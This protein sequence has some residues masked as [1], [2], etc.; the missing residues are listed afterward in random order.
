ML[1]LYTFSY[2]LRMSLLHFF[3]FFVRF[4]FFR[5]FSFFSLISFL[6]VIYELQLRCIWKPMRTDISFI[7]ATLSIWLQN[8]PP[9]CGS[10]SA[11]LKV[12]G[13]YPRGLK[14]QLYFSESMLY[15]IKIWFSVG[16]SIRERTSSTITVG[17]ELWKNVLYCFLQCFLLGA[18]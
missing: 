18:I 5:S 8:A 13:Y 12:S 15:W 2:M 1:K 6:F 17:G 10:L 7:T 4:S 16:F 14:F 11:C 9:V 3:F